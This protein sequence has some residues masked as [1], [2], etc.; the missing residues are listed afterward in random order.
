MLLCST[1]LTSPVSSH[2]RQTAAYHVKHTAHLK[3]LTRLTPHPTPSRDD[4]A[5]IQGADG[6]ALRSHQEGDSEFRR[7]SVERDERRLGE[8]G[9]KT[10]EMFAITHIFTE[11]LEVCGARQ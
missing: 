1:S 10:V 4:K 5:L 11:K 8:L 2:L 6:L 7:D 9:K 3:L